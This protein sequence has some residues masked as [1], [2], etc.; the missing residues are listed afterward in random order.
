[1]KECFDCKRKRPL[2]LFNKVPPGDYSRDDWGGRVIVC[3]ICN[4]KRD[5]KNSGIFR[6]GVDRKFTF[7]P[8]NIWEIIWYNL[9][10]N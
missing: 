6:R 10:H 3:K 8:K 4:T 2:A 5:L 1:M 9:T 7:T